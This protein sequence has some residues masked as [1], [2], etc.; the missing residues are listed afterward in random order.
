MKTPQ[1]PLTKSNDVE[2]VEDIRTK[3]ILEKWVQEYGIDVSEEF[4][5]KSKIKLFRCKKSGLE[6][7][8][9]P[10]VAGSA[11]LYRDLQKFDWYYM[12]HKWEH[13]AAAQD[14]KAG[15]KVLEVGCGKGDFVEWISRNKN[16]DA[17]GIELNKEA[18]E[19][20]Q[21]A[22]R[23][24]TNQDLYE[25]S[26]QENGRYDVVCSFQVLEHI[27]EVKSFIEA[28]LKLLRPG[29]RFI[30]GVP[31]CAGFQKYA[32]SDLLNQPPHH[33]T[34]WSSTTCKF[35]PEV[36]PLEL[37]KVKYEPLADYHLDWYAGIQLRR[38]PDNWVLKSPI[39]R[40]VH[41]V[42]LPLAR[43]TGAHRLLR[44]HTLYASFKKTPSA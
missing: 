44:G 5:R 38:L 17:I 4:E 11:D 29:G 13:D 10:S 27:Y 12:P 6:F 41:H 3:N 8:Y 16:A 2:K 36:L 30:F 20:A 1:S 32:E 35:L 23:P 7:Y 21:E 25:L 37:E 40:L 33:M 15:D 9:P 42:V 39:Y 18:V 24:V 26:G 31:N 19:S 22:G 43:H 14:I 28:S 34:R